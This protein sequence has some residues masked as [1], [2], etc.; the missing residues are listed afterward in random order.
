PAT[1]EAQDEAWMPWETPD[2][3]GTTRS[4][5]P[6]AE[7]D[8]GDL[9]WLVAEPAMQADSK[10]QEPAFEES[11]FQEPAFQ[12]PAAEEVPGWM[13]WTGEQPEAV[14]DA[15]PDVLESEPAASDVYSFDVESFDAAPLETPIPDAAVLDTVSFG[16]T[17]DEPQA[18]GADAPFSFAAEPE[19]IA[20]EQLLYGT[21]AM[22]PLDAAD[23]F[24][25]VAEE[26]AAWDTG[27]PVHVSEA[28]AAPE[29]E[30]S[31]WESA[32]VATG[33]AEDTGA[34]AW[35]AG[36]AVEEPVTDAAAD[37]EEPAAGMEDYLA[38]EEN[39]AADEA[40][41]AP[42]AD[43]DYAAVSGYGSEYME[44]AAESDST[45]EY[46]QATPESDYATGYAQAVQES[47]YA[48]GYAESAPEAVSGFHAPEAE[49]AFPGEAAPVSAA[50]AGPAALAE[51][52]ADAM[53]EVAER[54]EGIARR[55][56]EQPAEVLAGGG[57]RDPLELLVTGF[58]L[59][60]AQGRRAAG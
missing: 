11:T 3:E 12:E 50:D 2:D 10:L 36:F 46:T 20:G 42:V 43:A 7:D 6:A 47:D 33:A 53:A 14:P 49:S 37:A 40:L 24:P 4:E 48:S 34:E 60:Y 22:E 30:A 15:E 41:Y 54:L 58:A 52:T 18:F 51:G 29:S 21:E 19:S 27:A 16:A 5:A 56:R 17:G 25:E 9:P 26:P 1:I 44:P 38:A 59:G 13:T 39:T 57:G 28:E 45:S 55:L 35:S 23:A 31:P 32:D 8:A